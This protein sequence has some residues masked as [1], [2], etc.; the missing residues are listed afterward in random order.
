V[1]SRSQQGW[2]FTFGST[3]TGVS[4]SKPP[5]YA[6]HVVTRINVKL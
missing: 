5:S 6:T 3:N 1:R 2:Y 4:A